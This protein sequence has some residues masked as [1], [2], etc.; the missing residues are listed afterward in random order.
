MER[1]IHESS[2]KQTEQESLG[3]GCSEAW[4]PMAVDEEDRSTGGAPPIKRKANWPFLYYVENGKMYRN[5]A[6]RKKETYEE[7]GEALW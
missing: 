5:P 3:A 1:A 4:R 2:F 7:L 6:K